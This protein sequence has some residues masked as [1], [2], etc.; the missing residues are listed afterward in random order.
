MSMI[1]LNPLACVSSTFILFTFCQ[2]GMLLSLY[3]KTEIFKVLHLSD[4]CI[5]R[6][7]Q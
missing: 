5:L 4:M 2:W 6:I 1:C 7:G 3:Y